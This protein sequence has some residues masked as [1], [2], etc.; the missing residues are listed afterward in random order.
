MTWERIDLNDPRY[1][2]PPEPPDLGDF[3][4]SRRRHIIS[5][6]P[7][8]VKTLVC[9]D[10][11]LRIV[12]TGK[13]VAIID[14]E[15]GPHG[16]RTM[17]VELGATPGEIDLIWFVAPDEAPGNAIAAIIAWEPV[18][19]L[20][21]SSIGA[22][23]VS[24]L[25]D[26]KRD[27][28]EQFQRTWITPIRDAD[29]ATIVLDHVVKNVDERKN[30]AIGSERKG[31]GMDVHL[32]FKA[33]KTL[34]RGGSGHV[35]VHV[36]KDRG[37]FL[38]RPIHLFIDLDSDAETHAITVTYRRPE[39]MPI[40]SSGEARPTIKMDQIAKELAKYEGNPLAQK[41]LLEAVGGNAEKARAALRIL[42][43]EGWVEE[44]VGGTGKANLY[45]LL[46]PYDKAADEASQTALNEPTSSPRPNLVQTSSGIGGKAY[47]VPSSVPLK[48]DE[49]SDEVAVASERVTSSVDEGGEPDAQDLELI[50]Y[51]ESLF[52]QEAT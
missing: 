30:F 26:N 25:D 37:A 16:A 49:G 45:T 44:Q 12:R 33:T 34:T 19:V 43:R 1:E 36:H 9:Y 41:P 31:G 52:N 8:S 46:R 42:V 47:L 18:A 22:F 11:L 39:G 28:V 4:Y 15:M 7:E 5:G 51:Y 48:G 14:F 6:P 38:T 17:L 24:G 50:A 23:S 13:R 2:L 32:G 35:E 40:A 20:I 27:Q 29:I 21:D 10:A 3:L